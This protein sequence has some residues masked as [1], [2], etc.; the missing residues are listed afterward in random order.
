MLDFMVEVASDFPGIVMSFTIEPVKGTVTSA[1]HH[2]QDTAAMLGIERD[3]V[4]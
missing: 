3:R 2:N 1:V 4:I